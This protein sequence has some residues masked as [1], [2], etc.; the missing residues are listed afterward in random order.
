MQSISE[1]FETPEYFAFKEYVGKASVDNSLKIKN[2][3]IVYGK[4][5]KEIPPFKS[6]EYVKNI[7]QDKKLRLLLQLNDV[8]DA[9]VVS[10]TPEMY[11]T[12]YDK[13]V[14][15]IQVIDAKFD[16][17]DAFIQHQ[18]D[19]MV[20]EPISNIEHELENNQLTS[21][22]II[23]SVKDVV[24]V[25]KS[26]I[27]DLW[28]AHKARNNLYQKLAEANSATEMDY[29]V[30]PD[31]KTKDAKKSNKSSALLSSI[32]LEGTRRSRLSSAKKQ[33]IKN[34]VKQIMKEKL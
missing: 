28:V 26:K 23:Q 30:W 12:Q 17:I 24:H 22:A 8:Y 16:E 10:A 15:A 14:T 5:I 32:G 33:S 2:N 4:N 11:K 29:I 7:L 31:E 19:V 27:K 25:D 3:S 6:V 13:L 1:A 34:N 20:Y 21:S 18:N 9:I